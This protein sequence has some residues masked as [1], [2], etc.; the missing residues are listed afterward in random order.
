MIER[1]S[2]AFRKTCR[3]VTEAREKEKCLTSRGNHEKMDRL[4]KLG[5]G[6]ETLGYLSGNAADLRPGQHG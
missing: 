4:W 2:A 5:S 1:T 6:A 3:K